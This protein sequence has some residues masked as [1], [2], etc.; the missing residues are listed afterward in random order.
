M[1]ECNFHVFIYEC[2]YCCVITGGCL[3]RVDSYFFL[4]DTSSHLHVF[5]C[6]IMSAFLT[7]LSLEF[8]EGSRYH[9]GSVQPLIC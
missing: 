9:E 5:V 1:R 4:P 3:A 2:T 8:D 6:I 7:I